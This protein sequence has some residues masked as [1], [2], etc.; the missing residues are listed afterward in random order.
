[1]LPV[2]HLN[3]NITKSLYYIKHD[4]IEWIEMNKKYLKAIK[5][6]LLLCNAIKNN[7]NNN[8]NSNNNNTLIYKFEYNISNMK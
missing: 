2:H 1:M 8:N 4:I 5:K 6:L 3:D 7:N